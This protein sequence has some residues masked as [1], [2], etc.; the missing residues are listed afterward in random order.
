MASSV[1]AINKGI[2]APITFKGLKAQYIW[3]LGGGVLV[4]FILFAGLYVIGI[5]SLICLAIVAIGGTVLFG[6]VY[7]F[8]NTYGEFG[9]LKKAAKRNI[10]NVI[11][12]SSRKVFF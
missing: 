8:S 1:Y 9:L 6:Y 4:L 3:W 12:C 10:P 7:R 2:N 5:P 11:T